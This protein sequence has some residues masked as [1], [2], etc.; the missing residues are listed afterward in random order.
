M[1]TR[2]RNRSVYL[3]PSHPPTH[4]TSLTRMILSSSSA[5]APSS[6]S[7]K[8]WPR[9]SSISCGRKETSYIVLVC[10]RV[11]VCTCVC[12]CVCVCVSHPLVF[13]GILGVLHDPLDIL[14]GHQLHRRG[15]KRVR[16]QTESNDT[17]E[18]YQHVASFLGFPCVTSLPGFPCDIY[19]YSS[20]G[21]S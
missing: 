19:S 21:M 18:R 13:N 6:S 9:S 4:P 12:V 5:M 17:R 11:Y 3:P 16:G 8:F 7:V 14:N 15:P 1:D 2:K 20:R 10:A